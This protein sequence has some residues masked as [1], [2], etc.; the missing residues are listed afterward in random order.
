MDAAAVQAAITAALTAERATAAAALQAAINAERQAAAT[1]LTA[2]VNQAVGGNNN[3]P[4]GP[5]AFSL[6]P[7][8]NNALLDYT[9][10]TGQKIQEGALAKMPIVYNLEAKE[11]ASFCASVFNK[12]ELYG[13]NLPGGILMVPDGAGEELNICKH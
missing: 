9:S 8:A 5:V 6:G 10:R 2:A 12:G 3:P 1:A 13:Y 7:A 11:L 4:A